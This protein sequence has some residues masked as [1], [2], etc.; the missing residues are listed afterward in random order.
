MATTSP[1]YVGMAC[2]ALLDVLP[3][4]RT[5]LRH[6]ACIAS[7]RA[8]VELLQMFGVAAEPLPCGAIVY[9]AA[10][11]TPR[12]RGTPD[13]GPDEVG[14][15]VPLIV[16]VGFTGLSI[17]DRYDAHLIIHAPPYF[18]DLT[19]D[20][21]SRPAYG[22]VVA[23]QMGILGAPPVHGRFFRRYMDDGALVEYQVRHDA[24]PY[25]TGK[26]WNDDLTA[27][28][29]GVAPH[30]AERLAMRLREPRRHPTEVPPT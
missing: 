22:L 26:G 3:L 7:T 14:A 29:G 1:A 2:E 12:P 8:G 9:N 23:P 28:I 10:A 20:Q 16:Q 18:V 15:H 19:L 13:Y 6:D 27:L 24:P 25:R 11:T 17:P 5:K 4:L 21:A 30:M